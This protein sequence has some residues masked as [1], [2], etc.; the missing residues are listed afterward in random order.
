CLLY[1]NTAEQM[2]TVIPFFQEGLTRRERCLYVADEQ[3]IEAVETALNEH[4]I[5]VRALSGQGALHFLTKYDT[6]LR[7]GRFEPPIMVEFMDKLINQAIQQG[8]RGLRFA[9]EMTWALSVGCEGLIEYEAIINKW[10]SKWRAVSLCQYNRT[11]FTVQ[12]QRDVL[13]THPLAVVDEKL[14]ANFYYE[15]PELFLGTKPEASR[16]EWMLAN[17]QRGRPNLNGDTE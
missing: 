16:V 6:F 14:L 5:D 17:L 1:N 3:T 2:A 4:G 8:F 12:L 11:K 13:K 10:H 9:C 15:P 7:Y